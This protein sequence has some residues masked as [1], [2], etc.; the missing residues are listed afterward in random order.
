MQRAMLHL[1][2]DQRILDFCGETIKPGYWISVNE[3]KVDKYVKF[4]FKIKGSSGNLG[5]IVIG[6][7]MS[8]RDLNI[9]EA[10]RQDYFKQKGEM[11]EKLQKIEKDEKKKAEVDELK[12]AKKELDAAYIPIDFD[13]YT[14]EDSSLVLNQ[15]Q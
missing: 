7:S 8:H 6:D 12:R 9:L 2:H 14:I 13:A 3:D 4:D 1:Q 10:E 5:A 15:K 11:K